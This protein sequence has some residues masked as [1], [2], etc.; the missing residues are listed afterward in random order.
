MSHSDFL[1]SLNTNDGRKWIIEERNGESHYI[2]YVP[3]PYKT[4]RI[5]KTLTKEQILKL[6]RRT[7][8]PGSKAYSWR[9]GYNV[10]TGQYTGGNEV[11]I[12]SGSSFNRK[13]AKKYPAKK[14]PEDPVHV[15]SKRTKGKIRDKT[16]A[17]FRAVPERIFV[18]MTFI[19]HVDD[20]EGKRILN[21][22]L[23]VVR[24]EI[25]SF[26]YLVIAEH[27]PDREERTIHFHML[28]N[29]RLSIGRYNSLW[30][31]QQYNAGLTGHRADGQAITKA[32]IMSRYNGT[33]PKSHSDK[34][35]IGAVLNP[36]QI[37]KAYSISAMGWYLTKY[38]TKQETGEKFGCLTWHCS[39]KV[40]R[41]F[42]S[43]LVGPSTFS[44]LLTFR[45]YKMDR[46]TGECWAPRQIKGPFFTLVFVNNRPAVL[47]RLRMLEAVN[48]WI[49]EKFKPDGKLTVDWD[50][51]RRVYIGK[52]NAFDPCGVVG[53]IIAKNKFLSTNKID[54]NANKFITHRTEAR[55][56]NQS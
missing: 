48:E 27:Q 25:P 6:N 42:T 33:F 19:E 55:R 2:E 53:E 29:K 45:N 13:P 22:F 43:Q 35:T 26:E 17:F 36:V 10:C 7:L 3:N 8:S 15:M 34:G 47:E 21:K 1:H 52:E 51:Y 49:I 41:L 31:L 4:G 24:K 39:R 9:L 16:T 37:E 44:Y 18:T 11:P 46:T 5:K 54:T 32:E 28:S 20:R 40:S 38:V 14:A 56:E 12:L 23:T 50:K 30:T